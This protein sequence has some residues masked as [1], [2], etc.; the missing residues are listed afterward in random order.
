MRWDDFRASDN[1]EDRRGDGGYG[2]GGGIGIPMG[3]GGL[4]MGTIIIL[5]LVGWALGIDPRILIAGAEMMN[6]GGGG[7]P[8]YEQPAQRRSEASPQDQMGRFATKILGNTEDV[9][10]E[11]F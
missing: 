6:G 3:R 7:V 10:K 11:V 1:V 2:G 9:W 8:Q 5:G 4:G